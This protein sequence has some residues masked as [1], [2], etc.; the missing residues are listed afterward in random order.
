MRKA[1]P[2]LHAL[3]YVL[4]N[5]VVACCLLEIIFVVMLHAPRLDA[6]V[7]APVRRVIQQVYRHFNRALIQFDANCAQYDAE[8]TYTLRPGACTFENIEFRND[9]RINRMGLRDDEQDLAAPEVIVIGDSH[10]MGW[11]VDQDQSLVRVMAAKTGLKTLNA[12]ISSYGTVR[13]LTMLGR[14]RAPVH[15]Q[16]SALESNVQGGSRSPPHH[17]PR[18]VRQYRPL[19]QVAALVLPG[20]VHVSPVHEG[21]RTG[22]A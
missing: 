9:Y 21:A 16:R 22:S 20:Q 15:G 11:G 5:L 10:A 7:P 2:I 18:G 6:A 8:V 19:L 12:A 17:E 1:K 14:P 13:E 4:F 3:A